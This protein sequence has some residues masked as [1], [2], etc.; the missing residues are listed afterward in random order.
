MSHPQHKFQLLTTA[1]R[2][3]LMATAATLMIYLPGCNK[4]ETK[5]TV[6]MGPEVSVA[7]VKHNPAESLPPQQPKP[8]REIDQVASDV[9]SAVEAYTPGSQGVLTPQKEENIV[10]SR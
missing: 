7:I 9:M 10:V 1:R 6:G 3:G 4:T 5:K 8:E 2:L